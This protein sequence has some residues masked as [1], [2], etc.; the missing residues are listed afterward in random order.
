MGFFYVYLEKELSHAL[1]FIRSSAL[2]QLALNVITL[3]LVVYAFRA[4]ELVHNGAYDAFFKPAFFWMCTLLLLLLSTNKWSYARQFFN[5]KFMCRCGMYS[6]GIYLW[7]MVAI[8][9]VKRIDAYKF[10]L[11]S[12]RNAYEYFFAI[13]L[14]S[15]FIGFLFYVFVEQNMIKC[16]TFV[17]NRAMFKI[18]KTETAQNEFSY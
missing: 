12:F 17:C 10:T 8:K 16:A 3:C 18:V 11:V 7:H 14:I 6:F 15:Y 4:Y 9:Q 2:I 13:F 1:H 5:N